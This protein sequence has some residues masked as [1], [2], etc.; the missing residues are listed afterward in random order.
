MIGIKSLLD[1]VRTEA[2]E[3]YNSSGEQRKIIDS[4]ELPPIK[5]SYK[6][7]EEGNGDLSFEG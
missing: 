3:N 4:L 1:C 5:Y 2:A 7:I 6:V